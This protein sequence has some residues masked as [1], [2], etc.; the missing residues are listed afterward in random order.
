MRERINSEVSWWAHPWHRLLYDDGPLPGSES[1]CAAVAHEGREERE[2]LVAARV[3]DETQQALH[4]HGG[5][6]SQ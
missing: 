6:A 5:G 2:G 3:L 4:R 1:G